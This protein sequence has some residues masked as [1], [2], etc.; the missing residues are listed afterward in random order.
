MKKP[1]K[2]DYIIAL[3]SVTCATLLFLLIKQDQSLKDKLEQ[4]ANNKEQMESSNKSHKYSSGTLKNKNQIKDLKINALHKQI[5][6]LKDKVSN[7]ENKGAAKTIG[8][9]YSLEKVIKEISAQ[10]EKNFK[11][12]SDLKSKNTVLQNQLLQELSKK[13]ATPTKVK[14]T[15]SYKRSTPIKFKYT[16]SKYFLPSKAKTVYKKSY[17]PK[18]KYTYRPK[19]TYRKPSSTVYHF[20]TSKSWTEKKSKKTKVEDLGDFFE[21]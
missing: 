2:K 15:S 3:L 1:N 12:L 11:E 10:S 6:N 19:T 7:A 8:K 5:S 18:K 21:E 16:P 4:L 17:T 13:S 14:S 20:P 9:L